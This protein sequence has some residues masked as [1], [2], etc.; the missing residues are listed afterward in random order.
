MKNGPLAVVGAAVL[1]GTAGTAGL[2]VSADS[3]ALAAARL[4]VGGA[5]LAVFARSGLRRALRPGLLLA[6][7][8]VAAYQLCF[9]A[10]VAR[11]GVAIG[12]VVAIGSGPV[13]TGLLSWA[14]HRR[15]PSGRWA[16]ATAAAVAGCVALIA[17]GGAEAGGQVVSGVL[18]ALLGGLLYAFY[19]VSAAGAIG[20]GAESNAVMGVLF[21]GAA[22]LMLPVLLWQGVGWLGEP[23]SLL[24]VLY[25]GLGTT[26]LSYF[27]YGRGL[28]T[29]PVAT[30]ATL[31]LA[32]PAVAA[33]LGL[34]VLG[35]RLTPVSVAGLVLLAISLV[36]VA[37]PEKGR[38]TVREREDDSV[39][40][41]EV[42]VER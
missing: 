5:A 23:A 3:V 33:L 25:L 27:L 39:V 15:R 30:A 29:T 9:F 8:A 4:V 6:A 16:A 1:W 31:A 35:E 17:G 28:R 34:V 36:A 2:L 11:T 24:A 40:G 26:A 18:L 7:V 37:L 41:R 20:A 22:V 32:E 14:L 12:T 38:G 19:A 10:A 13:F 21:G 42:P